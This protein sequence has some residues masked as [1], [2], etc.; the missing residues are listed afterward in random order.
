[1]SE[2]DMTIDL[3]I[4]YRAV[5]TYFFCN[6]VDRV[7]T[8]ED[9]YRWGK[10][11]ACELLMSVKEPIEPL[12]SPLPASSPSDKALVFTEEYKVIKI[13]EGEK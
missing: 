5:A 11:D 3:T 2:K 9:D 12:F 4:D 1:M 7:R 10:E 6:V 8:R 13:E